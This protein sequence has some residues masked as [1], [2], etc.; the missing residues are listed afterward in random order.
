V[1]LW[2]LAAAWIGVEIGR[3]GVRHARFA[4]LLVVAVSAPLGAW[5]GA[6]M[7]T[8]VVTALATLALH[9]GRYAALA[10]GL[11]AAWRPELL[12]WAMLLG[13]GTSLARSSRPG[14]AIGGWALAV[15][16]A[17]A[18]ATARF[19]AFGSAMPLAV[20]AKP[21][22]LDEG[23]RYAI[24]AGVLSAAPLLVI[25]PR[26]WRAL[27]RHDVALMVAGL[28]HLPALALAGGDWMPLFRLVVPVLPGFLV[29][30][31]AIAE[32][33]KLWA[34]CLR[35]GL[36]LAAALTLLVGL[37]PSSRRVWSQRS[38]LIA[39]ARAPL[40]SAEAVATLDAGWVGVVAPG[41]VVDAA[42]VTDPSVAR[43][44]GSHTSKQLSERFLDERNVDV[45]LTLWDDRQNDW[46][47]LGDARLARRAEAAGWTRAAELPLSGSPF[48]YFV[49]KRP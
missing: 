13:V 46:F 40:A 49:W 33:S 4:P 45:A 21:A 20:L 14:P 25:A 8:G 44:A 42:G 5:A 19:V 43:L 11:A 15:A 7:E 24:G 22:S 32:Q 34:T 30:G 17:V 41:R 2:T 3:R 10:A 35:T 26:T 9:R 47:R 36:A 28:G 29:V 38:A 48:R 31:A 12:P 18:V 39:S 16:P 27:P 1:L 6:G 37:G 23:L